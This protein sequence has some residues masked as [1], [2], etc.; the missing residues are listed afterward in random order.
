VQQLIPVFV[1]RILT[2]PLVARKSLHS[3]GAARD[4]VGLAMHFT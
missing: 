3:L 1:E 2:T 4:S